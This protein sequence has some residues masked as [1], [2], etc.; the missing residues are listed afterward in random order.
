MMQIVYI[1]WQLAQCWLCVIRSCSNALESSFSLLNSISSYYFD[2]VFH[3]QLSRLQFFYDYKHCS[4]NSCH[5]SP[6]WVLLG[7]QVHAT[8]RISS[9]CSSKW[10]QQFSFVYAACFIFC[11]SGGYDLTPQWGWTHHYL[12]ICHLSFLFYELLSLSSHVLI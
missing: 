5:T 4:S 12:Y 3:W 11:W 7:H 10:G 1:P 9:D 2:P 6:L 8:L